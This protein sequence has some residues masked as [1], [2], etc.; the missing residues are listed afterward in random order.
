M[1]KIFVA[2]S[3]FGS[4]SN[5]PLEKLNKAGFIVEV[6]RK[7]RTLN[8]NELKKIVMDY[9]G[10]IAGTEN[11]TKSVLSKAKGLKAISRL[12]K[13]VDNI[14]LDYAKSCDIV[15]RVTDKVD[16]P[17]SVAELT[18]GLIIDLL[19]KISY[20]DRL[21][22]KKVWQKQMGVLLNGKTLGIVGLG[23]VGKSLV[24]IT[25]KMGI[26]YLA[27]DKYHDNSFAK[28]YK[29]N[30]TDLDQLI[31]SSDIVSI[32]LNYDKSNEGLFNNQRLNKMKKDAIIIN[33]SR[34]PIIEEEALIDVLVKGKISGAGLDVYNEEPYTGK[35]IHFDNVIMTPHI[36]SYSKEIRI[37]MENE[38]VDNI[39]SII[40]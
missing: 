31:S 38:A 24:K 18:L 14:D 3:T 12:G 39:I 22:R 17:I 5:E 36:G 11:Y 1:K 33:T 2:P 19:K 16:L 32:H 20:Q 27:F 28:E 40:K 7:G 10:I 6:N 30:Y 25:S 8:N 35:L 4:S 34:G 37:A 23:S 29:I 9:N 21:I 26:K 15:I 13:G